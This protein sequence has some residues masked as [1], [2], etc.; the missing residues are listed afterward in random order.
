VAQKALL[1][2]AHQMQPSAVPSAKADESVQAREV[3]SLVQVA[4]HSLQRA[5][6][7]WLAVQQE[8]APWAQRAQ[9][10]AR[11]LLEQPEQAPQEQ[12]VAQPA[13][14]EPPPA[15]HLAQPQAPEVSLRRWALRQSGPKEQEPLAASAQPWRQLLSQQFP[16][17]RQLLPQLPP[18]LVPE[19]S[20][21]LSPRHPRVSSSSASSS[22]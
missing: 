16:L 18:P 8:P 15:W 20:C 3:S 5:G 12:P 4:Q 7:Q 10:P 6:E 11:S 13:K 19:C 22:P 9:Q 17:L 21:E 14:P 2:A 1:V